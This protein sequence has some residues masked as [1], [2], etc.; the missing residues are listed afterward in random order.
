MAIVFIYKMKW[1]WE[2]LNKLLWLQINYNGRKQQRKKALIIGDSM[3]KGIKRWKI[4]KKLKFS[5]GSANCFPGA[6]TSDMKYYIKLS[7][8]K[9]SNA[10]VF[11]I[12]VMDNVMDLATDL[13]KNLNRSCDIIISSIIPRGDQLQQKAVNVNEELKELCASK[14]IRYIEHGTIH[15]RNHLNRSKLHFNFHGNTLFLN[16]ICKYLE[17]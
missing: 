7:I 10:E 5:N 12:H 6:N 2:S 16:N 8:K 11:I 13:K 9:N 14:N 15:P 17:C 4:N 3:V 1:A